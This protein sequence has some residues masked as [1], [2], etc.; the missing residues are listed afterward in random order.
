MRGHFITSA[1]EDDLLQADETMQF[2]R[3]RQ[4]LVARNGILVG[5]VSQRPMLEASMMERL[6][7]SHEEAI[8]YL[9]AH[10]VSEVMLL[11]PQSVEAGNSLRE[12]A[13]KLLEQRMACLPVV[14]PSPSGPRLIGLV[15]QSDLLKAAYA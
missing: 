12:A 11:G 14:E 13:V 4:L 6:F 8:E 2:A 5:L 1:P 10:P 9:R 7:R 15:T 3:L